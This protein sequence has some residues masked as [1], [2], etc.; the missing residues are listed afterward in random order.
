MPF[1]EG[2]YLT[3]AGDLTPPVSPTGRG[4]GDT[5][6]GQRRPLTGFAFD[7]CSPAAR[8][9]LTASR[10]DPCHLYLVFERTIAEEAARNKEAAHNSTRLPGVDPTTPCPLFV[11]PRSCTM[12][13][14]EMGL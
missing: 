14:M 1:L 6:A 8:S 4:T 2:W 12:C 3:R 9:P 10:G 5:V 11:A 7:S 13:A